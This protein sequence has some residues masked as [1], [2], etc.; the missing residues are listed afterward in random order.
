MTFIDKKIFDAM[1]IEEKQKSEIS[2]YRAWIKLMMYI[3]FLFSVS[4][5]FNLSEQYDAHISLKILCFVFLLCLAATIIA[6]QQ[7]AFNKAATAYFLTKTIKDDIAWGVLYIALSGLI[8]LADIQGSELALNKFNAY[9]PQGVYEDYR[10]DAKY[11]TASSERE[12][13]KREKATQ[14]SEASKAIQRCLAC[15]AIEA[16]Y[17][18]K[19]KPHQKSRNP[20]WVDGINRTI[21]RQNEFVKNQLSAA[22]AEKRAELER[23]RDQK[24]SLYLSKLSK[25]DEHLSQLMRSQDLAASTEKVK[26]LLRE[27]ANEHAAGGVSYITQI[28]LLLLRGLVISKKAKEGKIFFESSSF[29]EEGSIFYKITMFIQNREYLAAEKSKINTAERFVQIFD[30]LEGLKASKDYRVIELAK[31]GA[32]TAHE[33]TK[34]LG[35]TSVNNLQNNSLNPPNLDKSQSSFDPKITS[36]IALENIFDEGAILTVTNEIQ[37]LQIALENIFDEG[38]ILTVTNEIQDLQIALENLS[39]I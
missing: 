26:V 6:L 37:D 20:K 33:A 19:I 31:T 16:S 10:Q 25:F 36:Q 28:L 3:E 11:A 21:D 22:V 39:Q 13:L 30:E 7:M 15:D 34:I 17:R 35:D 1:S 24:D 2:R 32:R 8:I 12:K 27:K 38:A 9:K 5:C 18:L 14:W 23:L 29:L 4:Y